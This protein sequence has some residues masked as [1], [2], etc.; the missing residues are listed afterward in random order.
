MQAITSQ[1]TTLGYSLIDRGLIPDFV[2]RPIVRSLCRERVRAVQG[3]SLERQ[4][5]EKMGFIES[6]RGRDIAIEQDKANEQHYEVR[7]HFPSQPDIGCV[8]SDSI[9]DA[10]QRA[11]SRLRS[12]NHV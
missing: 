3:T 10:L 2:L 5:E 1:V 9:R 12:S 4:H 7:P 6:L 8:N 11:R